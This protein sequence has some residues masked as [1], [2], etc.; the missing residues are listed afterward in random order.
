MAVAWAASVAWVAWVAKTV[1]AAWVAFL[2]AS[3]VACP[4]SVASHFASPIAWAA[5]A[6]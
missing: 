2:A 1:L 6:P 5:L 4:A 3:L